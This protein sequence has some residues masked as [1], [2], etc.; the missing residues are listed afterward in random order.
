MK[1]MFSLNKIPVNVPHKIM[2]IKDC[3]NKLRLEELGFTENCIVTAVHISPFGDP[4]AYHVRGTIIALREEDSKNI[5]I[6]QKE[7][8]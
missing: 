1:E 6:R 3:A 4:V 7:V 5:I 8:Y 2:Y